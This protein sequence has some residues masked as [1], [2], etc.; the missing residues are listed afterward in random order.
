MTSFEETIRDLKRILKEQP[1]ILKDISMTKLDEI[2][3]NI[4]DSAQQFKE[5]MQLALQSGY[6]AL[7]EQHPECK[8]FVLRCYTPYFNDGDECSYSVYM[9][10]PN[11]YDEAVEQFTDS[12]SAPYL[13]L[14]KDV[15]R[16]N[17]ETAAY[18]NLEKLIRAIPN[19]IFRSA[20][21]DHVVVLV[22]PNFAAINDYE[23]HG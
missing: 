23:D 22:T 14:H 2:L 21:G 9:E 13:E 3:K 11:D 10:A 8:F 19:D 20:Y 16:L 7:F 5:Q 15:T 4:E 6:K 12:T 18:K 1:D 17:W